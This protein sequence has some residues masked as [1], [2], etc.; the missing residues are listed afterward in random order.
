[1]AVIFLLVGSPLWLGQVSGHG[2][3]LDPSNRASLWRTNSSL[4]TNYE[5]NQYNCGGF[6]VLKQNILLLIYYGVEIH[7]WI[8]VMIFT[9]V[10][11]SNF[12][13]ESAW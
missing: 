12:S 9:T 5:D 13:V 3:M 4:P 1:M 8:R 7:D 11:Y 10:K 2:M 6:Q